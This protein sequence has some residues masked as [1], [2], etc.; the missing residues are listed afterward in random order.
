MHPSC[1]S[2]KRRQNGYIG[3][4]AR[5]SPLGFGFGILFLTYIHGINTIINTNNKTNMLRDA[6]EAYSAYRAGRPYDQFHA[7]PTDIY[8]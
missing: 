3:L 1:V 8:K 7:Q 4:E 6:R 2:E 5:G